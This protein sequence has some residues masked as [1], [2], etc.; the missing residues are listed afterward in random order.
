MENNMTKT[1]SN[2]ATATATAVA[3]IA[4]SFIVDP[5]AHA[6]CIAGENAS[7]CL[8]IEPDVKISPVI[9]NNGLPSIEVTVMGEVVPDSSIV[10]IA[11]DLDE[12]INDA[13]YDS[14]GNITGDFDFEV[15]QE[16]INVVSHI[17]RN[18]GGYAIILDPQET[19]GD[20]SGPEITSREANFGARRNNGGFTVYLIEDGEITANDVA[21]MSEGG[22]FAIKLEPSLQ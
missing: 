1:S 15:P 7:R 6:R 2:F 3:A 22:A 9:G 5:Y 21:A 10:L 4:V 18:G 16:F 8:L 19:S 14:D 11:A 13:S 12:A 17:Q 20:Y